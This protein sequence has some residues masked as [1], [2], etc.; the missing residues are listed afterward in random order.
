MTTLHLG[1]AE[2]SR[3]KKAGSASHAQRARIG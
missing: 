3:F 1:H 2:Q